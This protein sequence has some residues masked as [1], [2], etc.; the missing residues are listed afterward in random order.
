MTNKELNHILI[1]GNFLAIAILAATGLALHKQEQEDEDLN[2]KRAYISCLDKSRSFLEQ[3]L[4]QPQA[5]KLQQL[6][7]EQILKKCQ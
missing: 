7:F 4:S 3:Q 6:N 5:E 2:S 1:G